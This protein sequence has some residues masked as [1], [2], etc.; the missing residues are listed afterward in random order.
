MCRL[1]HYLREYIRWAI[2]KTPKGLVYKNPFALESVFGYSWVGRDLGRVVTGLFK[3]YPEKLNE[4]NNVDFDVDHD[5]A[6]LGEMIDEISKGTHCFASYV[7]MH[8]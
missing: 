4:I 3:I 7:K 5:R 2:N 6:S 8:H 1:T